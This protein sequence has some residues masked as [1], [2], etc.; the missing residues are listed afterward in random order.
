MK[1]KVMAFFKGIGTIILYLVLSILGALLFGN[2]YQSEN[3]LVAG[4]S[5]L[6]TYTLMLIVIGLIYHKRLINDFKNFKKENINIALKN[7]LIGLGVMMIT[8]I[9]ITMF[10]HDIATNESLNRELL[11]KYPLSNIITMIFIG[12][13]LE[14]ITFR[15]SFKE[16]FSKWYTF[17]ITTGLLFGLAHIAKWELLEFLFVIPS[18]S[19]SSCHLESTSFWNSSIIHSLPGLNICLNLFCGFKNSS[20]GSFLA[21]L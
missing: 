4:L 19:R 11:M 16:A 8:N 5:Q 15:A 21:G 9:I 12:P 1:A 7:W 17:A 14:E 2:F 3:K 13:L 6:G 20:I 10:V 18:K